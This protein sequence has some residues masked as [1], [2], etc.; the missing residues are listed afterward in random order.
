MRRI[1]AN[2]QGD[3]GGYREGAY[4]V[5]GA[6]FARWEEHMGRAERGH[7]GP[8]RDASGA[9][10]GKGGRGGG[11]ALRSAPGQSASAGGRWTP[12]PRS[13]S[14]PEGGQ[15]ARAARRFPHFVLHSCGRG[16]KR[17]LGEMAVQRGKWCSCVREPL[18]PK[19]RGLNASQMGCGVGLGSG[20]HGER[21][22]PA[23]CDQEDSLSNSLSR[24][25]SWPRRPASSSISTTSARLQRRR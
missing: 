12:H 9:L 16:G 8:E 3:E 21:P 14:S 22:G 23:R 5:R 11:C 24:R 4:G 15:R 7:G 18:R 6:G 19:S 25:T 20:W 2:R 1:L 13:L 10:T 17:F